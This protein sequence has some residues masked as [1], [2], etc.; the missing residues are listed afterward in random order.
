MP[1]I[2]LGSRTVAGALDTT[3][4]NKGKFTSFFPSA[5]LNAN[6]PVFEAYAISVTGLSVVATVTVYVG[7]HVRTTA[8]ILGN[9]NWSSPQTILLTES[10]D[11]AVCWDFGTG[12]APSATVWLRYDT[13]TLRPGA[14]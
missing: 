5:V 10:D 7:P 2:P 12:T 6:L 14:A 11:L 4:L 8:K 1:Y 13:V 3:G 9:S